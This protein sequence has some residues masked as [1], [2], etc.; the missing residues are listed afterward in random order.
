MIKVIGLAFMMLSMNPVVP[1]VEIKRI[2]RND[3]GSR[4]VI[5]MIDFD[6]KTVCYIATGVGMSCLPYIPPKAER[7]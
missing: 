6:T 7:E 5:R 1:N 4:Q 2:A 3:S